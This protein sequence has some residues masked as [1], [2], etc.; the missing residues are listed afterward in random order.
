[1]PTTVR[2]RLEPVV[3]RSRHQISD[4]THQMVGHAEIDYDRFAK[5]LVKA[6]RDAGMT[7]GDIIV[8]PTPGMNEQQ[9]ARKI[10]RE[11]GRFGG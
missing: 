6:M 7:G 3:A 10:R 4:P 2:Q 11:M 5:A 1:M 8:K 9:L